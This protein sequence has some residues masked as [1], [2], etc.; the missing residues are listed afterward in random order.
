VLGDRLFI[1]NIDTLLQ[2]NAW[3]LLATH[4]KLGRQAT[5]ALTKRTGAPAQD[6]FEGEAGGRIIYNEKSK[7]SASK[8][9]KDL[10]FFGRSTG[11][12]VLETAVLPEFEWDGESLLSIDH[13]ML[14]QLIVRDQLGGYDNGENF[15]LQVN[16]PE[17]VA[18]ARDSE[19]PVFDQLSTAPPPTGA[20]SPV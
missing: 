6:Q 13:Q 20:K 1:Q 15:F 8:E 5:L 16:T 18:I 7:A 11:A 14:D 10:V 3:E 9:Y 4:R 2:I 12:L 17:A 19:S